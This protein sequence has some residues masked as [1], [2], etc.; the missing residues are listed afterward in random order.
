MLRR[1]ARADEYHRDVPSV[2]LCEFRI[3]IDIHFP[4]CGAKFAQQRLE[5]SLRLLAEVT[6][7]AGVESD[8]ERMS[9]GPARIF[10]MDAHGLGFEYFWKGPAWG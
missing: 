1:F 5:E 4:K 7:R 2:A 10:R 6:A 9:G 3:F 8:L